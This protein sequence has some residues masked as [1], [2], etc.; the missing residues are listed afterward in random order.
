[1]IVGIISTEDDEHQ[2]EESIEN[3]M[4][5]HRNSQTLNLSISD[6]LSE[7]DLGICR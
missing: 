2:E 6:L 1:M 5:E 3:T 7:R 4:Q